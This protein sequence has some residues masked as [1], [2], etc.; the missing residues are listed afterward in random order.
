MAVTSEEAALDCA[1]VNEA[2]AAAVACET[3]TC[4]PT[5]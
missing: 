2:V 4:H 1:A 3:K 5:G